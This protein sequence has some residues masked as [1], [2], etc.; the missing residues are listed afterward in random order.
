[1]A[2]KG[3][4]S[5]T[6]SPTELAKL[7]DEDET[8]VLLDTTQTNCFFQVDFPLTYTARL[9]RL[10]FFITSVQDKSP[11]VDGNAKI[12]GSNDGGSTWT[13][14]LVLDQNV[15]CGWNSKPFESGS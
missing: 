8:T 10:E 1:M 9:E 2:N 14:I 7:F 3:V 12:Q 6:T 13:D 4:W 5:G 11:Y 15:H